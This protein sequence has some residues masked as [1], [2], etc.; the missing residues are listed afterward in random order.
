MMDRRTFL[1]LVASTALA[2][3]RP[4]RLFA[5]ESEGSVEFT[6]E[7]AIGIASTFAHEVLAEPSVE[8]YRATPFFDLDQIGRGYIVDYIKDN[9]PYGYIVFDS[10]VE[11]F[12]SSFCCHQ[13][14]RSPFL[15]LA[16]TELATNEL[17][18]PIIY[19]LSPLEF[20]T[21]TDQ[22][23]LKLNT[24]GS[25]K[26]PSNLPALSSSNPTQWSQV[27]VPYSS[28]LSSYTIR[29]AKYVGEVYGISESDVE[30]LTG[31]YAC[32]VTALMLLS[33]FH[34]LGSLYDNP[35]DYMK[36]WNYTST[37][38]LPSEKQTV[39]GVTLGSTGNK[40][41]GPGYAKYAKEKGATATYYFVTNALFSTFKAHADSNRYSLFHGKLSAG[42][43]SAHTMT[44]QGYATITQNSSGNTNQMLI[45]ADGWN[46]EP[47]FLNIN[48]SYYSY[49]HATL[50]YK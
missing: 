30:S 34:G 18:P 37:S 41:C 40:N 20:A 35:S 29:S 23:T 31:H 14:S 27:L 26:I 48:S 32:A 1:T 24:G 33:E 50:L 28:T 38:A 22:G 7:M 5:D 47:M 39:S 21:P 10:T 12:I 13:N 2:A 8:A 44:V 45:V 9:T 17:D 46:M 3:N 43:A 6:P 25:I 19:R 42:N 4:K 36:L 16:G 15:K 49:T 11:G